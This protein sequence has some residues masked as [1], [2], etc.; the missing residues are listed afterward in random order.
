MSETRHDRGFTIVR[1]LDAPRELVFQAWTDPAQ[2]HWY[3]GVPPQPEHPSTVDLRVGGAWRVLLV[4][5]EGR[6]YVTGGIYH[7][8]DPPEKLV[9]TWGAVD[10]WPAI[11]ADRPPQDGPIAT[12]LLKDAGGKTEMTFS[13]SFPDH[14][15]AERIQEW[16]SVGFLHGWRDTIDRLAPHLSTVEH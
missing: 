9:F 16:F 6:T 10:G 3:A 11:D 5:P 1:Y 13:I 8:I 7:E 14:V 2:L 4:E 12:V 15:G